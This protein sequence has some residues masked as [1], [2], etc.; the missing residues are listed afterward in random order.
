M[1]DRRMGIIELVTVAF[2]LIKTY[3]CIIYSFQLKN[4]R[5]VI[6][7]IILTLLSMAL[8]IMDL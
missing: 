3:Y 1:S 4:Y 7:L 5:T 8:F 6:F 2:V